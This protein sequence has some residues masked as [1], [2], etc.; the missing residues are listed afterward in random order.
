M[1]RSTYHKPRPVHPWPLR[2]MHWLNAFAIVML[3]GSG[4]QIYNAAPLFNFTFPE[5]FTIGAWLGAGI[6][7]HLAFIWLLMLNGLSYLLWGFLS[8]HFKQK[9]WPLSPKAVLRDLGAALRFKLPH[10]SGVYNAVQRA[11]YVGVIFAGITMVISGL[12]IWK[13]VQLWFFTDLCGGYYI[14]RYVHF[15]A[16][17]CIVAFLFIHIVLVLMVPRVLPAMITGGKLPEVQS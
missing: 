9:L 1:G 2:L 14:A 13:P 10:Q 5:T 6:A 3:I 15:T 4:W 7:W 12:A 11:L 16:M 17:A 8:G